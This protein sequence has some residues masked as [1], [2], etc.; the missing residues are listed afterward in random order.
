MGRWDNRRRF[1]RRRRSP[2]PPARFYN[3]NAFL[4]G[5]FQ[6]I[7]LRFNCLS[8]FYF[9]FPFLEKKIGLWHCAVSVGEGC[10]VEFDEEL[11]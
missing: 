11:E 2:V 6:I 3:I 7:A 5:I 8:V 1:F 10:F 9:V 4:P